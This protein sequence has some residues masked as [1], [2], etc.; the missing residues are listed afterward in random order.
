MNKQAMGIPLFLWK[1]P[2]KLTSHMAMMS[3][4]LESSEVLMGLEL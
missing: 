2:G 3:S 1:Q 4:L